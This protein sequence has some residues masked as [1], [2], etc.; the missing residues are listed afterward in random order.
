MK[1]LNHW[2]VLCIGSALATLAVAKLPTGTY[3]DEQKAKAGRGQGQGGWRWPRKEGFWPWPLS[4]DKTADRYFSRDESRWKGDYLRRPGC[5]RH[6]P[7]AAAQPSS[8]ESAG[9]KRAAAP[10]I[11]HRQSRSCE[12]PAPGA[13]RRPPKDWRIGPLV[14]TCRPGRCCY[15]IIDS[16]EVGRVVERTPDSEIRAYRKVSGGSDPPLSATI[17]LLKPR[18]L[19]GFSFTPKVSR[20]LV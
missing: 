20:W 10:G 13:S 3:H 9:Q 18:F 1:T 4:R 19:R 14:A 11:K 2:L 16:S 15:A 5:R 6:L 17:K 7:P 12:E 8:S